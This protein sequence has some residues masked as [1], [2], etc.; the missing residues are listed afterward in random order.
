MDYLPISAGGIETY[1][2]YLQ[3]NLTLRCRDC[4]AL[5]DAS[6][7]DDVGHSSFSDKVKRQAR[8]AMK[9]K[10]YI[11]PIGRHEVSPVCLCSSC[12]RERNLSVP[13]FEA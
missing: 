1:E 5:F 9:A 11:S 12:A 13:Y 7:N 10:W 3:A 4:D 6:L 2:F 8:I